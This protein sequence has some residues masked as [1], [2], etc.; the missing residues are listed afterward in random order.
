MVAFNTMFLE[1]VPPSPDVLRWCQQLVSA[2]THGGLWGIPRSETLFRI[3]HER[4][5]LV[6]IGLG[7]DGDD[8]DF[9][10]TKHVFKHIGWD[11]VFDDP[12]EQ[13]HE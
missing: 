11:V 9:Y 3:D 2:L 8:S 6:C 13:T 1:D 5:R 4:K 10:A 7:P 12:A